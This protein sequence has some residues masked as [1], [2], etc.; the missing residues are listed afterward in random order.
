MLE[1]TAG[2]IPENEKELE[3][4]VIQLGKG[5]CE[6]VKAEYWVMG[7]EELNMLLSK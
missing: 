7:K 6:E 2:A 4:K 1:L 3:S 5:E